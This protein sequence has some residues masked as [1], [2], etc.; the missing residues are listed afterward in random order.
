VEWGGV[1]GCPFSEKKGKSEVERLW[2]W[3]SRSR[4]RDQDVKFINKIK[5]SFKIYLPFTQN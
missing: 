3:V 2:D 1:G 5:E 4:G